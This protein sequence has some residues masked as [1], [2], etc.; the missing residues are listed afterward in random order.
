MTRR[1]AD[2]GFTLIEIVVALAILGTG[3]V[4]LLETQYGTMSLFVKAQDQANAEFVV[5]QALAAAE[6]Q[7]LS[8]TLTGDGELG[9][10]LEGFSY[11][12]S[13]KIQDETE[14]PGLYTVTVNVLGPELD[15]TVNYL[16]YNGAQIDAGQ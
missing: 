6:T 14:T 2:S 11:S 15:R 10:S 9:P 4:V 7:V 5:G 3:I 16:V 12:F 1:G 8:G 13:A